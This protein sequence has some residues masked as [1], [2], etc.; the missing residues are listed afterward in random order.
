MRELLQA[1]Q[2]IVFHGDG[3]SPEWVAEAKRRG[4]P[5]LPGMVDA[6]PALVT[7]KS[8]NLF[9]TFRVYSGQEL[10]S[11]A[12]IL[13]ETYTKHIRIEANTMLH[14]VS[15]HF[16]P[17]TVGFTRELAETVNALSQALPGRKATVQQALLEQTQALLE[18][19]YGLQAALTEKLRELQPM[20]DAAVMARVCHRQV[21]PLMQQLRQAVDGLEL[22]VGKADWPVPT[23]GDLLFEV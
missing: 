13:Y 9:E 7:E 21:V 2:R 5:V 16:I 12:E 10:E 1:H 15:K 20:N 19:T 14:M 8:R 23:Y 4:L 17:V 11:R 6:I 22:L 3:Y 18:K